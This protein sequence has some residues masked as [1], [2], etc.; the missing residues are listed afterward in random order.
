MRKR[1]REREREKKKNPL[2]KGG[3]PFA[4]GQS[5]VQ[6][7][8]IGRGQVSKTHLLYSAFGARPPHLKRGE[9]SAPYSE[10]GAWVKMGTIGQIGS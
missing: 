4:R 1:E 7:H 2:N 10:G 9:S 8:C 5:L 6:F 3:E